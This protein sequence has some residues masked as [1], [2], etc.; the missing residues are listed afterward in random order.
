MVHG[1]GESLTV[2]LSDRKRLMLTKLAASSF[3]H[4]K[5]RPIIDGNFLSLRPYHGE[6]GPSTL[7]I[8]TV[9]P[10]MGCGLLT[11]PVGS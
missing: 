3:V 4:T 8:N 1:I 2:S 11:V 7:C 9:L 6:H 5:S 10:V